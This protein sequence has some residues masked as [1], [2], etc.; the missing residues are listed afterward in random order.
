MNEDISYLTSI[1]IDS[2]VGTIASRLEAKKRYTWVGS[3]VLI[4]INPPSDLDSKES[5]YYAQ[6]ADDKW[7]MPEKV[8]G[9]VTAH[10]LELAST[11]FVDMIHTQQDQTIVM[12]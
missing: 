8:D 1:D 10:L 12:R 3:D 2:I 7:S 6:S 4:A 9:N 5:L 11:A